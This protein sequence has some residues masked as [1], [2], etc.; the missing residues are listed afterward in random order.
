M[1]IDAARS[2]LE[3]GLVGDAE[4]AYHELSGDPAQQAQS[5]YGLGLVSL[6]K[7]DPEAAHRWFT[8]SVEANPQ[9]PNARFYLGEL[10]ASRGDTEEAT[11]LFAEVLA[12]NPRHVGAL[13]RIA[14]VNVSGEPASSRERE[15]SAP[16]AAPK[17][18]Q[19]V[20]R[21]A[22]A[23]SEQSNSA[24]AVVGRPPRPP[25]SASAMVGRVTLVKLQAV[26]FNGTPAA[27]QSLTFR[28]DVADGDGNLIRTIGIE[29]KSFHINGT[30]ENGD[31]VEVEKISRNGRVKSLSNL[32]TG[33]R[34]SARMF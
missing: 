26:P 15:S 18:P 24:I 27:K 11:R 8:K 32:S 17:S 23:A 34:V 16:L 5:F 4:D 1:D 9:E 30:V 3:R 12:L 33:Q 29:M 19:S 20:P 13:K 22:A 6:K 7:R 21:P 28:L 10:A 25:S 31:W 14:S 2:L